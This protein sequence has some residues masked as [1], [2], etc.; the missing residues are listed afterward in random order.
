[1]QKPLDTV[2]ATGCRCPCLSREDWTRWLPEVL[3]NLNHAVILWQPFFSNYTIKLKCIAHR[4]RGTCHQAPHGTGLRAPRA[5][6]VTCHNH[7]KRTLLMVGETLRL[8][9]FVL[10]WNIF[11]VKVVPFPQRH[12]ARDLSSRKSSIAASGKS[13]DCLPGAGKK[14]PPAHASAPALPR[15]GSHRRWLCWSS[16]L[17]MLPRVWWETAQEKY[18]HS[19][20]LRV[21]RRLIRSQTQRR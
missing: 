12:C 16:L 19:T 10:D 9:T 2:L 18:R 4:T 1:M 17:L 15:R 21:K 8:K 11:Q 3:S 20:V 5:G 6:R 7:H 13:S 14:P